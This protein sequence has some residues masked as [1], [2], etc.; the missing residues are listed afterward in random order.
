MRIAYHFHGI[1]DHESISVTSAI[2]KLILLA[3]T[4]RVPL[5]HIHPRELFRHP[6]RLNPMFHMQE[7]PSEYVPV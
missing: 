6:G 1:C 2:E 5:D 7:R 3:R 4:A